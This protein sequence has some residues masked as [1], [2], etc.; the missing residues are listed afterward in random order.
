MNLENLDAPNSGGATG[1]SRPEGKTI[2]MAMIAK[3]AGVSQGA[4]SSLLNDR[5]YG[6]RV[7]AK[8][9]ERVFRVC[10]EMGYMP[11]DLRAVV[12]MYPKLG[13]FA[14]LISQET[15]LEDPLADQLV[16][17]LMRQIPSH[18]LA[19]ATYDPA[20]DYTANPDLLPPPVSGGVA[21]RFLTLGTPNVSLFSAI[22]MHE[23]PGIHI[24]GEAG[25]AGFTSIVPQYAKGSCKAI[26]TLLALGHKQIAILSGPFGSTDP[27][28][29]ELNFG[30][31]AAYNAIRTP[32]EAQNVV[33]GDSSFEHGVTSVDLL[34]DRPQKPTAIFCFSALTAAGV[35]HQAQAR[36]FTIPGQLSVLAFGDTPFAPLLHPPLTTV[37]ISAEEIAAKA[38]GD[39]ET[40]L[41]DQD[42]TTTRTLAVPCTVTERGT[43]A[44]PPTPT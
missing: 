38:L 15:G 10:R 12:R 4:I 28:V 5:D 13:D 22:L 25:V 14:L 3:A 11:N 32:I 44:P 21:S 1:G 24:G 18:H 23:Y 19:V 37:S 6:I 20:A 39:L 29:I 27:T 26:E 2:T 42:I 17:S 33:Y 36:G 41:Q 7:S 30:I 43:C 16:K 9:R 35:L 8:T 31:R 34:L 40:R